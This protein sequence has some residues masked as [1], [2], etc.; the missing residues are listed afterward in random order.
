MTNIVEP[1]NIVEFL[2]HIRTE[3]GASVVSVKL[4]P[5]SL[6]LIPGRAPEAELRLDWYPEDFHTIILLS[7]RGITDL[8]EIIEVVKYTYSKR[9]EV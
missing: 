5:K 2:T 6:Y 1:K 8:E 7:P 9:G 3:T 4:D